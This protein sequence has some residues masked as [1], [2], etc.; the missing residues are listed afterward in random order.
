SNGNTRDIITITAVVECDLLDFFSFWEG[1]IW[2]WPERYRRRVKIGVRSLQVG[3]E[4]G[5]R[6]DITYSWVHKG[7]V[8]IL[9]H[10]NEPATRGSEISFVAQLD[11]PAK[12]L[13]LMR[14]DRAEE[15]VLQF[16]R[17]TEYARYVV[18]LPAGHEASYEAVG[19][20][21]GAGCHD[22]VSELNTLGQVEVGFTACDIPADHRMGMRIDL[23]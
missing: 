2:N 13:P 15:F 5:I 19:L 20:N 9:I 14:R 1:P 18:V 23:K 10:L 21:W 6:P 4:G 12:C 7:R 3:D 22:L 8:K 17:P 11:W 16:G